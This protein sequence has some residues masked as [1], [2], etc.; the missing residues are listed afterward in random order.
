MYSS[1]TLRSIQIVTD[2]GAISDD[3]PQSVRLYCPSCE[4]LDGNA[5]DSLVLLPIHDTNGRLLSALRNRMARP[6]QVF[7][8]VLA[9]DPF[10]RHVDIFRALETAGCP[11]VVNFPSVTAID[12]EMRVSLEN[13]GYGTTT[14]ISLLRT[15]VA[16]GFSS[17]AVIDSFGMAQEAVT[18]GV[19]GLIA[20]RHVNDAMLAELLELAHVTK[21]GLFRLPDA[22]DQ[23]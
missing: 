1:S 22:V 9:L 18:V 20:A 14:E 16:K 2:L 15:A 8:G 6:N 4:G 12:G 10:R 17:L 11:G 21:L 3:P 13:F 23:A 19:S 5:Y 7:A